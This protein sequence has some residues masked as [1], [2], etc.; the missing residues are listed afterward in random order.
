MHIKRALIAFSFLSASC[1]ESK[2]LESESVEDLQQEVIGAYCHGD[3]TCTGYPPQHCCPSNGQNVCFAECDDA[4]CGGCSLNCAS[5]GL[6]CMAGVDGFC[7]AVCVQCN[8]SGQCTG[9]K[10]CSSHQC[11]CPSGQTD[12]SGTCKNLQTDETAC[13]SCTNTCSAGQACVSGSCFNCPGGTCVSCTTDNNCPFK[14]K[15]ESNVCTG[16]CINHTGCSDDELCL[17]SVCTLVTAV[18]ATQADRDTY[19]RNTYDN[20]T[21]PS[22]W[23]M[24]SCNIGGTDRCV[25]TKA[26]NTRVLGFCSYNQCNNANWDVSAWGLTSDTGYT[27]TGSCSAWNASG[28][29]TGG[30]P[31]ATCVWKMCPA[32]AEGSTCNDYW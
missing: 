2:S 1:G 18:G 6:H 14:T 9:G 27:L 15:C 12:C 7:P 22:T 5:Q 28:C 21:S 26:S 19:C 23:R 30:V 4:H 17:S 3:A 31:K 11:V 13:G 24:Q 8:S 10:I 20:G 32:P 29:F 25:Q 16:H